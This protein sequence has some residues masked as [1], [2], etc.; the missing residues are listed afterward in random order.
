MTEVLYASSAP[1]FQVDGETRGE[2][3]R[4]LLRL[5]VEETTEGLATLCV[6]LV[7]L[8]PAS[9]GRRERLQYLDGSLLDFGRTLDVSIGPP[10]HEQV[11]FRGGVS[12]L[13]VDFREHRL[14]QVLVF[15]EDGLMRLRMTRRMR[16]YERETDAGIASAIASAHGLTARTAA[17]GPR[18]D[19]VQQ[20]N[21]SDLA[22]LRERA[23]LVQ[24]E[25]WLDGDALHFKTRAN[26]AGPEVSLT[27]GRDL[28]A[29]QVRADLAHQRSQVKV[30]GYDAQRRAVIDE[31]AGKEAIAAEVTD[32]RTGPSVLG[33]AF[34]GRDVG[35][36]Y[37]V[38]EAPL[39][40]EEAR[41][42]ARAE[43]LRRSRCF[44]TVVGTTR[45]TPELRVGAR[46]TLE[47][48]GDPFDGPGYYVTGVRH[49]Y[50]LVDGHRTHFQA[51]RPT[52]NG[53][54]S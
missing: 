28:I 18:Y 54:A 38:R 33:G 44:V 37:R 9:G 46:V 36:A 49:T 42:W 6:Y 12:A 4:D 32:G 50:D 1:V 45:G 51:E 22:F 29:V 13:E 8:G 23:R 7:A 41:A 15:A 21:Q 25:I 39:T 10:G 3:A 14:P 16:S 43:M 24:A 47:E 30:S 40:G 27:E 17:D 26:R 31:Q 20:L 2:L 52:I 19:V 35:V 34:R 5:E 11:I 53:A 48:T